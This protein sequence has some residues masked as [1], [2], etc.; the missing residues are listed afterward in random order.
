MKN[1]PPFVS[2]IFFFLCSVLCTQS[3]SNFISKKVSGSRSNQNAIAAAHAF[4]SLDSDAS[5]RKQFEN[6]Q[7]NVAKDGD[8]FKQYKNNTGGSRYRWYNYHDGYFGESITPY[9]DLKRRIRIAAQQEALS[10]IKTEIKSVL[11]DKQLAINDN[12]K[13]FTESQIESRV[14]GVLRSEYWQSEFRP[15]LHKI[16]SGDS[17]E[18]I[19]RFDKVAYR[20]RLESDKRKNEDL[21][22]NSFEKAHESYAKGL[23][24]KCLEDMAVC[25][26]YIYSGGNNT[27]VFD[28]IQD[29]KAPVIDAL[30][31]LAKEIGDRVGVNVLDKDGYPIDNDKVEFIKSSPFKNLALEIEYFGEPYQDV[32]GAR[33]KLVDTSDGQEELANVGE[34]RRI[35]FD[36]SDFL[37]GNKSLSEWYVSFD[38]SA[39]LGPEADGVD[40]WRSSDSY[41]SFLRTLLYKKILIEDV[42][43]PPQKIIFIHDLCSKCEE[44]MSDYPGLA[45]NQLKQL[46][47]EYFIDMLGVDDITRTVEKEIQL[48][49]EKEE[50]IKDQYGLDGVIVIEFIRESTLDEMVIKYHTINNLIQPKMESREKAPGLNSMGEKI[51]EQGVKKFFDDYLF[52]TISFENGTKNAELRVERIINNQPVEGS[53][54]IFRHKE[55]SR[56]KDQG[57]YS[58]LKFRFSANG[59]STKEMSIEAAY[60]DY[61]NVFPKE[62]QKTFNMNPMKVELKK[63]QGIADIII[64]TDNWSML[65]NE[66]TLS[67]VEIKIRKKGNPFLKKWDDPIIGKLKHR[68]EN[69]TGRYFVKISAPGFQKQ[70]EVPFDIIDGEISSYDIELKYKSKLRAFVWSSLLPGT[71]HM[72]MQK[73]KLRNNILPLGL[74][75]LSLGAAIKYND[76]YQRHRSNFLTYQEEFK[77]S[78]DRVTSDES[79]RMAQKSW[80]QMEDA[81]N[82]FIGMAASA[83]LTNLVTSIML[84]FTS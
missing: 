10:E 60:L 11:V 54:K 37:E 52:R 33:I 73:G 76:S 63:A 23:L 4:G 68:Y 77:V 21:A 79:R 67:N 84:M 13:N 25:H 64:E 5:S 7:T 31:S 80:N 1:L 50:K 55:K 66:N 65:A 44:S 36:I 72:Y 78:P 58:D 82:Y 47:R 18:F 28:P 22:K 17:L 32:G 61:F 8:L 15:P 34:T 83:V 56:Y 48:A 70:P 53:L 9:N 62:T 49:Y 20:E 75:G 69:S 81:K 16:K 2:N 12:Y 51:V 57:R 40:D 26:Y 59:Y 24:Y 29:R 14:S 43:L 41:S 39:N 35:N 3:C 71:G 19:G 27:Q 30:F 42:T 45:E 6:I 46:G 74:Y 38:I